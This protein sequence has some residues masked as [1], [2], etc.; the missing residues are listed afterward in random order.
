MHSHSQKSMF[1]PKGMGLCA[2][3]NQSIPVVSLDHYWEAVLEKKPIHFI[4]VDVTGHEALVLQGAKKLLKEAPPTFVLMNYNPSVLTLK[5]V[6]RDDLTK[7]IFGAKYRI[8]DCGMK[9]VGRDD[10]ARA[11]FGAKYWMYDCGMKVEIKSNYQG[12]SI[13]DEYKDISKSTNLLLVQSHMFTG[14]LPDF[15]CGA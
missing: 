3:T 8:Y 2:D 15:R 13:L 4:R 14:D 6:G 12:D 7:A 1:V 11:I 5:N 9:N 10:V